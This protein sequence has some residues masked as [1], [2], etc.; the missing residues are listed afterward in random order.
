LNYSLRYINNFIYLSIY[1]S[2]KI[3]NSLPSALH[4]CNCPDTFH[5][6]LKTHYFQLAFSS[7]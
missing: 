3:W 1:L 4:S 2:P 6:H 5:R 7:P